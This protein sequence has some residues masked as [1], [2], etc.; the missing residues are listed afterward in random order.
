MPKSS[1]ISNLQTPAAMHRTHVSA[2]YCRSCLAS[3]QCLPSSQI[4]TGSASCGK[5]WGSRVLDIDLM[6]NQ[7]IGMH[8]GCS[9]SHALIAAGQHAYVLCLFFV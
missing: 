6:A 2:Q 7:V 3:C 8:R 5:I 4:V 1:I 9:S